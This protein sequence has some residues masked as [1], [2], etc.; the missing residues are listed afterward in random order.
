MNRTGNEEKKVALVTG[1]NRGI[2]RAIAIKLSEEGYDV[3]VTFR[4]H[5]ESVNELER[6]CRGNGSDFLAVRA[7]V[8][9][10]EQAKNLISLVIEKFP[11]IDV[12]VNNA[13]ITKDNLMLRMSEADFDNVIDTNLKGVFNCTKHILR[14]MMKQKSGSIINIASVVGEVGNMGQSNYAASKAGVIGFTKSIAKE[15]APRNIRCNAVAPGFIA[16]DMTE[17]LPETVQGEILKTIPLGAW[18]KPEDVA[19]LVS[20]LAGEESSYITGQVINVDGGMVM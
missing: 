15:A 10:F 6:I 3:A 18:G 5:S 7:D 19:K 4:S 1:G 14:I 11:R 12:L 20:F 2:G 13:G 9:S 8:S 17:I 16:T